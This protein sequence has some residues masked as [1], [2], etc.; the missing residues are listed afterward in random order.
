MAAIVFRQGLSETCDG[1]IRAKALKA[2]DKIKFRIKSANSGSNQLIQVSVA[3]KLI[4]GE[5][6]ESISGEFGLAN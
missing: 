3:K 2:S 4:A 5:I 1:E 6:F